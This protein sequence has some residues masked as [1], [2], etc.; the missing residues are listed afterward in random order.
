MRVTY[1]PRQKKQPPGDLELGGRAALYPGVS[2]TEQSIR[3]GFIRKVYG[4]VLAQLVLTA[5]VSAAVVFVEPLQHALR[6]SIPLI[7]VIIVCSVGG[8]LPLLYY[9]KRYPVNLVL[10]AIWTVFMAFTAGVAVATSP[11]SAVVTAL[12]T[13]AAAVLGITLYTFAAT[14]AGAEFGSMGPFLSACLSGFLVVTLLRLFFPATPGA[15][16][17]IAMAGCLLFSA[18]LV[19]DTHRL[20]KV[21]PVDEYIDASIGLYLDILNLFLEILEATR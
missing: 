20:I 14:S 4:I 3:W 2:A 1:A 9:R 12:F 18:Y 17:L 5:S 21:Y 16:L 7:V 6:T 15:D 11:A 19:Y 13:T 10:L 8:L